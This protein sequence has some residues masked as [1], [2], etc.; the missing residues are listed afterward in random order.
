MPESL[1]LSQNTYLPAQ[2]LMALTK[3]HWPLFK[4]LDLGNTAVDPSVLPCLAEAWPNL[5]GLHLQHHY[6]YANS[7]NRMVTCEWVHLKVLDLSGCEITGTKMRLLPLGNWPNLESLNLERS[8][9]SACDIE[10]LV[11]GNWHKLQT[12]HFY[13]NDLDAAAMLYLAKGPWPLLRMLG[14]AQN[15]RANSEVPQS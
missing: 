11:K 10:A 13:D 8:A 12:L 3:A 9:L 14:L 5:Q 1:D 4:S 2:A 15:I 6:V 7:I